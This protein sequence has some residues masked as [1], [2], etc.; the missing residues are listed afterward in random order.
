MGNGAIIRTNKLCK[1]FSIGGKQL[2]VIKNLDLEI[3]EGA[4]TVI[5][6]NSGSGKSTLLYAIS[7]MDKTTLGEV[8]FGGENIAKYTNDELAV[9]RRRNCGFV[10]QQIHL[11]D[12][13]SVMDNVLTS[14]LLLTNDK[15]AI[16]AR[17]A[18]LFER[19]GL[20]RELWGKF[21]SQLSGG[22]AQRVGIARALINEPALLFA[23]EPTGS[24]NSATGAAVLDVMGELHAGG[25]S[26]VVVTHDIKTAAR[27]SRILY[28]RDGA[29]DG[30]LEM[31]P[32]EGDDKARRMDSLQK[33]LERMGW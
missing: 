26:L 14:G 33:F 22:E 17:A 20:D 13:M 9:F 31:P 15:K 29:V 5:M 30:V 4:Y 21:P 25:Q 19:V 6:G 18:R 10:F 32:Y 23:D 28:L 12:S 11:M 3:E 27:G 24:L 1:S 2:H 16:Y 8:W 7:G